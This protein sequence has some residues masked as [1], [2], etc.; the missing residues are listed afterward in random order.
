MSHFKELHLNV[1]DLEN[2][3]DHLQV[4]VETVNILLLII[5]LLLKRIINK[6]YFNL[7]WSS[8]KL[9]IICLGV[10]YWYLLS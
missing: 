1:Y 3:A 5:A 4:E 8:T 2:D 7:R 6:Q 9:P 10:Y